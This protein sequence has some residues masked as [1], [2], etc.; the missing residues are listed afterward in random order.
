[1][2]LPNCALLP[3]AQFAAMLLC[4]TPRPP[5]CHLCAHNA[6]HA[7]RDRRA[8]QR[9]YDALHARRD[10]RA[11]AAR[12]AAGRA[13]RAVGRHGDG[14]D[15]A[16]VADEAGAQLAVGEVPDLR[17]ARGR[18]GWRVEVKGKRG[19]G[20][21]RWSSGIG[22]RGGRAA[23][24][25]ERAACLHSQRSASRWQRAAPQQP[26]R[27]P[28]TCRPDATPHSGQNPPKRVSKRLVINC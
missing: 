27:R 7:H 1:M 13:E 22:A 18:N 19:D 4:N 12:L 8:Q 6:L 25:R 3:Q 9:A 24:P 28:L 2:R 23:R 26:H 10:G 21:A 20:T 16:G 11:R 17:R 5:Y 15:V 14:V